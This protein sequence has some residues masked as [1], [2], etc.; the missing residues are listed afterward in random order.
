[1]KCKVCGRFIRLK[2]ENKY[3]VKREGIAPFTTTGYFD[4]FDCPK[5]GCQIVIGRRE[6]VVDEPPNLTWETGRAKE[7][8]GD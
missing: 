1:M 7:K 4:A 5:C 6:F 2:K 8:R 3:I